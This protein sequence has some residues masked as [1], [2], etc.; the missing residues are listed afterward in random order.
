MIEQDKGLNYAQKNRKKDNLREVLRFCANKTDCRRSQVLAFFNESFDAE[1]CHQGCDVCLDRDQNVI[2]VKDVTEDAKKVI[3]MIKEFNREDR[4][5]ITNAVDCFRGLKG[6]AGK[7]L[8]NNPSFGVGKGWD[9]AEAE[10]LVQNV[11]IEKGLDEYFLSNGA[12]WSNAYLRVSSGTP[13]PTSTVS[14]HGNRY[15]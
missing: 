5:T 14:W 4:I 12:G 15:M 10:R 1:D 3:T 8:D 11:L 2:T 9:R 7:G 13:S 6:S